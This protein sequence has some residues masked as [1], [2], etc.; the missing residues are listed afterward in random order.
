MKDYHI[1]A[2]KTQL[3]FIVKTYSSF[4]SNQDL[5][6]DYL[7]CGGDGAAYAG[8]NSV[9]DKIEDDNKSVVALAGEA[10]KAFESVEKEKDAFENDMKTYFHATCFNWDSKNYSVSFSLP[11]PYTTYSTGE[12]NLLV[13]LF[14]IYEFLGSDNKV[15]ILDD[16]ASS[17][18]LIN[19]YKIAYEIVRAAKNEKHIV[20]LTHSVTL[21]NTIN[22]QFSKKFGFYYLE[23]YQGK[24]YIQEIPSSHLKG[25]DT[26]IISLKEIEPA[27]DTDGLIDDLRNRSYH[28]VTADDPFH[29]SI[30]PITGR[31]GKYTN[32]SLSDEI[33]EYSGFSLDYDF[34]VNTYQKI[35]MCIA[36][37]VWVEK[38]LYGCIA[39]GSKRQ[40]DFFDDNHW[41]VVDKLNLLIDKN[42]LAKSD[43]ELS[44]SFNRESFMSKKVMLNETIHYDSQIM[45]FAYAINL[46]LFDLDAEIKSIKALFGR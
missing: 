3:D 23:N 40:K 18:D 5:E 46:S 7:I 2:D 12:R 32:Y 37:R 34:F 21:I 20:V 28:G 1:S 36:L 26:C 30:N 31:S 25:R 35:R 4:K 22:G 15:M 45:P 16:P 38:E 17:L 42:G 11:R 27:I 44:K 9:L 8:I 43:V 39:S 33:D 10:K 29:Y 14:H 41:T 19:Q 6:A 13:F 24:I